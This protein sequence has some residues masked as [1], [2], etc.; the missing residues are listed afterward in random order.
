MTA[1]VR[2]ELGAHQLA[3][4]PK[5]LQ[6]AHKVLVL[7]H[8][9]DAHLPHGCLA[10]LNRSGGEC[11][12]VNRRKPHAVTTESQHYCVLTDSSVSYSCRAASARISKAGQSAAQPTNHLL[13]RAVHQ[14]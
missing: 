11:Y 1:V 12:R 4:A 13:C 6:Q 3:L 7:E 8:L 5:D 9:E 14:P 10:H 2:A